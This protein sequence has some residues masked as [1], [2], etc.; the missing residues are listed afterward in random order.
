MPQICVSLGIDDP[1]RLLAEHRRLVALGCALVEYRLD[2]LAPS[3]NV[4]ELIEQRPGPI[5]ATV[6]LPADGG[7]WNQLET[8]RRSLLESAIDAGAEYVDLEPETALALPRRGATKRIVSMH[9]FAG[10]PDDLAGVHRRLAACD[11]DVV[12]LAVTAK[13]AVDNFRVLRLVR[14][15]TV[16]TVGLCMGA[17]GLASRVLNG[18]GGSPFSYAAANAETAVA[19]GQIAFE[20]MRDLYRYESLSPSTM[21]AAVIGDPIG[22]SK[23]PLIHNAAF[24]TLGLDAVYVP[25]H[26]TADV[27]DAFVA[28]ARTFGL[29]GLSVT[30]PHKEA[31][32][33]HVT[34]LD[35]AAAM[36]GAV[37]TLVFE[38]D[39]AVS[40]YNTDE[41][42]ALDSI[43]AEEAV[44][45][46][47]V[48]VLGAGGAAKG[49]VAGLVRRHASVVVTNRNRPRADELAA[50][51]GCGVVDWETRTKVRHDVLVNC[52]P[53]GMHPNV[54]DTP[55]PAEA[56]LPGKVVFDTVYNPVE[57]RLLREAKE[58]G[59]RT[60]PGTE[61]F[62]RQ[63]AWQ[64]K[65]FTGIE[66]PLEAMRA[67]LETG[68]SELGTRNDRRTHSTSSGSSELRVPSSALFL[69]GYRGTGK[70]STAQLL[71]LRLGWDWVDADVEVELRAGKSIAAIFAD[72]GEPAFRDLESAVLA[73]LARRERTVVA[74][75]GG[76]VMRETNRAVIKPLPHVVWLRAAPEILFER[77]AGDHSTNARRPNLTARGGL[78]EVIALVAQREPWYR[79]CAKLEIDTDRDSPQAVAD[80]IMAG[81]NL[82]PSMK[83]QW[84]KST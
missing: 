72:D 45:G 15:A 71:A 7:R 61:M 74:L 54:D 55:F 81:L 73:D 57:T 50:A 53:L 22:H 70:T 65:Y 80:R 35:P 16:P 83:S 77:I 18:V 13:T 62:L 26:V 66:A 12:K 63:A 56:L 34:R 36:I 79:E 21:I 31:V 60:V 9:D 44:R 59:C 58:T 49:I 69:I 82:S 29:R 5:I 84:G 28:E 40:G 64:F 27:L 39:G 8:I 17:M 3:V 14:E 51:L 20:T 41:P 38:T 52:T 33:K 2:Y 47:H 11:A 1:A 78:D 32:Q 67:A 75:G 37:N 42:G 6:R 46:K 10:T 19:P 4:A 43:E 24:R 68:N 25:F 30:I 48:L 23:S 76:V